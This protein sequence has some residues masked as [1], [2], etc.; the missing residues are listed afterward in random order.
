M[1]TEERLGG[2]LLWKVPAEGGLCSGCGGCGPGGG[3]LS[4]P[5]SPPLTHSRASEWAKEKREELRRQER[6]SEKEGK[7]WLLKLHWNTQGPPARFGQALDQTS[8]QPLVA[9]R[10]HQICLVYDSMW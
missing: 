6:N 2:E 8:S 3:K 4:D 9:L 5:W 1:K 10:S 7:L